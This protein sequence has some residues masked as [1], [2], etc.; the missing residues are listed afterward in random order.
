MSAARVTETTTC[1]AGHMAPLE[2]AL[3]MPCQYSNSSRATEAHSGYSSHTRDCQTTMHSAPQ[4][5]MSPAPTP[6][7]D[8]LAGEVRRPRCSA[9]GV[10]HFRAHQKSCQQ[11]T[12][13]GDDHNVHV[14]L[15]GPKHL[16]TASP[17]NGTTACSPT[18][19]SLH[20]CNAEKLLLVLT[21]QRLLSTAASCLACMWTAAAPLAG[22][23][24]TQAWSMAA[25]CLSRRVVAANSY[26]AH[27]EELKERDA[28]CHQH[29]AAASRHSLH[30]TPYAYS[31]YTSNTYISPSYHHMYH[32]IRRCCP[33]CPNLQL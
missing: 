29:L 17:G 15:A 32:R 20:Q 27:Q 23:A 26:T 22:A 12:D 33:Y 9:H 30:G 19:C 21:P 28:N 4:A 5:R 16:H 13:S 3:P 25:T 14:S 24:C 8:W 2:S 10:V 11:A 18:F 31:L 7:C 6:C 1:S